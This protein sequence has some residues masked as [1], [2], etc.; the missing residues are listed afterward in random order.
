MIEYPQMNI[1]TIRRESTLHGDKIQVIVPVDSLVSA[2]FVGGEKLPGR[3]A[4]PR[5]PFELVSV[6]PAAALL[7]QI[8]LLVVVRPPKVIVDGPAAML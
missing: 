5:S 2:F 8:Y 3:T 6:Q 4:F 7:Y 1:P